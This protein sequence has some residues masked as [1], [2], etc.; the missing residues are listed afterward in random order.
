VLAAAAALVAAGPAAAVSPGLDGALAFI[1]QRGGDNSPEVYRVPEA[2]GTATRLTN[3]N[4]N[5]QD[6]NWSP[7]GDRIVFSSNRDPGGNFNQEV[8]LMGQDG[9][10]QLPLTATT[11]PIINVD[12]AISPD[13]SRVV[14][15]STRSANE[16]IWVMPVNGGAATQLTMTPGVDSQPDWSPD[17]S[18]IVFHSDRTGNSEIFTMRASDGGDVRQLTND[19]RLDDEP[20]WSPDGARIAFRRNDGSPQI[21]VMA[22]ADGSGQRRL[23][24]AGADEE[25][26]PAWSPTGGRLVFH[27]RVGSVRTISVVNADG[28]GLRRVAS[29]TV[30][31]ATPSWQPLRPAPV[32]AA[33]QPAT[34]TAGGPAFTLT[35]TGSGFAPGARVRWNGQDRPTTWVD[36]GRLT[37]AIPASD[38]ASAGSARVSVHTPA[39]GGG[40]SGEVTVSIAAAT[41]PPPPPDG[42][43]IGA[44]RVAGTWRASR[45]RGR[46]TL[47][48]TTPRAA[49]LRATVQ[50]GRR[51]VGRRVATVRAGAFRLVVTLSPTAPPGALRVTLADAATPAQRGG[52]PALAAQSTRVL[53]TPPPEGVVTRAF[54]TTSPSGAPRARV[55]RVRVLYGVFRFAAPP[56]RVRSLTVEWRVGGFR[57]R[58]RATPPAGRVVT[59]QIGSLGGGRLAPGRWSATL[60]AG[61]RVVAVARGRVG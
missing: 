23:T 49:R 37:A 33:A 29:S 34:V 47:T 43:V 10:S 28:S 46:V 3:N 2:G 40:T 13:G 50:S 35:V 18:R 7:A 19:A 53:L 27:E 36:P 26:Q 5:D 4:D 11:D 44:A 15:T 41:P 56:R 6:T 57:T 38:V 31:E 60:R 51:V 39:P 52:A 58:F 24:R 42:L 25:L 1:D 55:G 12:G 30:L 22:A 14:F 61:G 20:S 21:W 54:L 48:G 17:G 32:V 16:D 8:F 9:S 59:V 45:V